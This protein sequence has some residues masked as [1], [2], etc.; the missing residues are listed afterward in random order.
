MKPHNVPLISTLLFFSLFVSCAL[1]ELPKPQIP[2]TELPRAESANQVPTKAS[3]LTPGMVTKNIVAKKTSQS[4]ILEIFGPPDMITKSG[5]GEMW[6]YDRVSREVVEAAVGGTAGASSGTGT[7]GG[8]GLFVAGV[9]SGSSAQ[10]STQQSSAQNQRTATTTTLFL[11]V[12]FD[13]KGIV[14]DYRISAT[15][16]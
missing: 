10:Q 9:G 15:K 11:L 8:V 3:N 5:A 14:N 4:E 1:P 12:Y 2:K 13:E 6:G 7:V 16:F